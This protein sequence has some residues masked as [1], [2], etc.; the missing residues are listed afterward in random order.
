MKMEAQGFRVAGK[1]TISSR[2]KGATKTQLQRSSTDE[3]NFLNIRSTR[4]RSKSD[5][6]R[7]SSKSQRNIKNTEDLQTF[8]NKEAMTKF[9]E[10]RKFL[11]ES[12]A[13]HRSRSPQS[14]LEKTVKRQSRPQSRESAR[15]T[16]LQSAHQQTDRKQNRPQS[17]AS[18]RSTSP[19]KTPLTSSNSNIAKVI[20]FDLKSMTSDQMKEF[21]IN[22]VQKTQTQE[23]SRKIDDRDDKISR[24]SVRSAS[25]GRSKMCKY[26]K[27]A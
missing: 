13:S 26:I 1:T 9:S 10:K 16:S 7:S 5:R 2:S 14:T 23:S 22:D 18:A 8:S 17:R 12:G 15:S 20:Q 21:L 6:D 19:P 3:E 27:L 25:S 24:Q 4:L 11:P